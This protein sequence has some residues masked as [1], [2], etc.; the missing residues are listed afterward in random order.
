M[1]ER[2]RTE[3][4]AALPAPPSLPSHTTPGDPTPTLG[5]GRRLVHPQAVL[6]LA[7][8]RGQPLIGWI[9]AALEGC[10]YRPEIRLHLRIGERPAVA[11]NPKGKIERDEKAVAD[12]VCQ[13]AP[14]ALLL[15]LRG[16]VSGAGSRRPGFLV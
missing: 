14:E 9:A 16:L 2:L 5:L 10:A 4:I 3:G 6:G 7:I 1:E 11:A 15:A 13:T 12:S 8:S